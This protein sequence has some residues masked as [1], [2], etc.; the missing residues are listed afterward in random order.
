MTAG[1]ES[2]I[3][4][5]DGPSASAF[6]PF[7]NSRIIF[8]SC[9]SQHYEQPFWKV[10]RKRNSTAFIWV[11]DAVYA[12]D[13]IRQSRS[14][15]DH[16]EEQNPWR[17]PTVL[18]G[19]SQFTSATPEYLR[20]LY[21]KQLEVQGYRQLLQEDNGVG[22]KVSIFG[23]ID[24]H[25]Y[26]MNNG[27]RT[28]RFRR[29]SGIEFTKFLGLKSESSAMSRRAAKGLGVYGVQVYD[30][31]STTN[32]LLTDT[33]AGLDPDVVSELKDGSDRSNDSDD[34]TTNQLVAVF[35]L[36]VRS[37]KTPWAKKIPDRF[38][39]DPEGDFLGE[40]QWKWLET[41]IG[42]SKASV[43]I[44][45]SGIQVHAPWFYDSNKIENWR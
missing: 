22:G 15:D 2:G 23:A 28:F 25:D 34:E 39:Q 42:R 12:D 8:G 21:A 37:N 27:D 26:G 16:T 13:Q 19:V 17:W 40:R 38:T 31:S 33:E 30:F 32:R 9:N 35:V 20:H 3:D 6:P 44:V 11:G 10:I 36:D 4:G 41:A 7:R 18:K 5:S 14:N 45:V 29:E 43:N 24:D 1:S